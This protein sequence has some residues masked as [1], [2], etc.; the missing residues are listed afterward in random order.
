MPANSVMKSYLFSESL[1]VKSDLSGEFCIEGVASTSNPDL[2]NDIVSLNVLNQ[3]ADLVNKAFSSGHPLP[4]GY[5]HTEILG[6]HPDVVPIGQ[7]VKGWVQ[8]GKLFVKGSLNKALG[9]FKEAR[10]ALE[11]KDLHALSIEF[12]AGNTE[13][14]FVNGVKTRVINSLKA[15]VT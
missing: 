9:D 3:M 13:D 6:G 5:E 11:R 4:L 10:S 1:Q 12:I 8:D 7:L 2:G 14:T 15:L